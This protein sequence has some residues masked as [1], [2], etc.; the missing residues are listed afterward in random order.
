MK[1]RTGQSD[2][3][4]N[5]DFIVTRLLYVFL[6]AMVE[7]PR[8]TPIESSICVPWRTEQSET[9][10]YH[11]RNKQTE[12]YVIFDEDLR[13][14]RFYLIPQNLCFSFRRVIPV[15]SSFITV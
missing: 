11:K 15:K 7:I 14:S 5:L 12:E 2:N 1:W 4:V 13:L 10:C 6:P 8:V 3:K 9:E